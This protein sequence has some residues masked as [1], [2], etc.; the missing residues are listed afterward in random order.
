[1]L[2]AALRFGTLDVQS[3][4]LDESATVLLV[5]R[6]FTGML[7]HL[8]SSE[9]APPLYYVLVWAWTKIFGGDPL[10]VRSFSALAG[11]LTVP[12][13]YLAGKRISVRVGLWAAALAAVSPA[14]YYYSQEARGYALLILLSAAAFVAWQ[15]ALRESTDRKLGWWSGL[16]TLAL[17]THYFAVFMFL[18]EVAVLLHR[19][20]WRRLRFAL[21]PVAIV[22]AALVPLALRQRNGGQSDWIQTTTLVS[23]FA[24]APKQFLIGLYSP[25]EIFSAVL[26]G[27]LAAGAIALLI[28]RGDA[29]ER[30]LAREV[31]IIAVAAIAIPL[32]LA[33]TRLQDVFNGRNVMAAWTPWAVLVAT[34]LGVKRGA[35]TAILLG[36]GLCTISLLVIL[37]IDTNPGYQRDNWRGIAGTLEKPPARRI[38]VTEQN[39]TPPL[40]VYLPG[41]STVHGS[42]A[43]TSEIDFLALR[44]ERT[45]RAPL[46]PSVPTTAPPGFRFVGARRTATY[47]V[48]RFVAPKA[49]S[50]SVAA[51]RH[52]AGEARAE[53]LLQP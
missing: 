26:A 39:S 30:T 22:A 15:G 35:W 7:S 28:R 16:S 6:G 19:L 21:A 23:R 8:P 45:G 2:A 17:L 27:I 14:L 48:S 3:L 34:G 29:R 51:L 4:W 33:V 40:E 24:Q 49:R 41:V 50:V 10:A 42:D 46:P 38:L 53:V 1:M 5:H 36:L 18:P 32:L 12:V 44:T 25:L 52:A 37:G 31:A 9:S 13:L 47:A 43:Q 11:T 20:G